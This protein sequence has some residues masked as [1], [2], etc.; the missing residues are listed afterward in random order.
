MEEFLAQRAELIATAVP[1]SDSAATLSDLTDEAVRD[2]ARTAS[3]LLAER[4]AVLALGGW[5]AG[6]L[7]PGSDLD[8]LILSDAPEA[9]LKPFVEALLYPLWDAGL[10]VGHQVRSPKQQLRAMRGDL[11]TCTAALT[12]RSIAGD[13]EWGD[14]VAASCARDVHRRRKAFLSALHERPR[15]GSPYLLEPELKEGAGGRRDYDE[16][17]WTAAALSGRVRSDLEPLIEARILSSG[18]AEVVISAAKTIAATRWRLHALGFGDALTSEAAIDLGDDAEVAQ[19]ALA[20]TSLVLTRVRAAMRRR[21]TPQGTP[22]D[23]P[24]DSSA[25]FA[26]LDR[27][28]E[29]LPDLELAATSGA[30]ESLLPGMRHLMSVRRPG[31]GHRL[32]VG[33]H[34]LYTATLMREPGEER[35]ATASL[36]TVDDLRPAQVA[37][38]THDA[39]KLEAGA[40]HAERGADGA[41]QTALRF[42]LDT[43]QAG[44]VADLVKLHLALV[45]TASREDLDDEDAIL[46]CAARIGRRELV[47][48]LHLLTV[49]DSRA[50][51]P[52]TWTP[53][54]ST[55]VGT[56]VSRLDAALSPDVDGAGL[57]TQGERVRAETLTLLT[58][59]RD[60]ERAFVE[61][62]PLRYLASRSAVEVER[63]VALVAGLSS[64]P[65]DGQTVRVAVDAG[66]VEGTF[67]VTIVAFDR[68]ELLARLAGAVA[69]AGLDILSVDAYGG[70]GRVA[71]DSFVVRS[72]TGAVVTPSILASI[73]DLS[74]S[75][76]DDRLEL[77]HRLAERR[78]HYPPRTSAAARVEVAPSGWDTTVVVEAP[79]RPG[80]LH[81]LAASV[82]S[83]GLDIRWARAQTVGG[84]A[85]DTFHVVGA[86]GG[87][88]TDPG[89]LG[90][91]AMRLRESL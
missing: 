3:S 52:S 6:G 56:L 29:A 53:W 78:R 80:L 8:I 16:L 45:E 46:R 15:P 12:A 79:D 39:A 57:A 1:G 65:A 60:S 34:C 44:D 10:K 36:R 74:E 86:D 19:A 88:V 55:L 72:A 28:P 23:M 30:L 20:D 42:G 50:T 69:L 64:E 41:L 18:D 89:I 9:S 87:P 62:A 13:T 66:G 59:S 4:W 91:L 17:C 2:L 5:G 22:Q 40:G 75:A 70:T 68:P 38:L 90:H 67:V 33:A 24:L 26:L 31:L 37:A 84:V 21:R 43:A 54:M 14:G 83:S 51:G 25:L 7:L 35:A 11:K 63:D 27:G 76:L 32:T 71:L 73:R 85:R 81:D 47:A 58:K 61:A 49:A 77:A 82:S 48:P